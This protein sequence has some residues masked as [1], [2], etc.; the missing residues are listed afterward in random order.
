M[1][2]IMDMARALGGALA[3]TTEHQTLTRAIAAADEDAEIAEH[4]KLLE[5]LEERLQRFLRKG[6]EPD[7]ELR[8][9][10]ER[11]VSRLQASSS[12]Q[13]LVAS[14]ANFDKIVQKVNMQIQQGLQD[15]AGSRIILP[16]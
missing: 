1:A 12:Y 14:Q 9:E 7:E 8:A 10:Y 5:S 15:G 6:K 2:E 13:R 16:T 4:T 3:R 11:V